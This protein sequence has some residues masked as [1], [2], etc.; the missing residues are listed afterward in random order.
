MPLRSGL[1]LA[2]LFAAMIISLAVLLG[3]LF[4][5][6]VSGSQR[7][8]LE[9]SD[10]MRRASAAEIAG[11]ID[12]RLGQA[13]IEIDRFST[14]LRKGLLHTF[15][16]EA[17]ETSF[18]SEFVGRDNLDE[19]TF[20]WAT[21][22][23]YD[24]SGALKLAPGQRGQISVQHAAGT[25]QPQPHERALITRIITLEDGRL[26]LRKRVRQPGM[27]P[28]AARLETL[29]ETP[30]DPT[31][32]P[33]FT[34]PASRDFA[35]KLLW[36]DLHW[37]PQSSH[38]P[39]ASRDVVVTLQQSI[40]DAD[41]RF[42][43]VLRL[44]LHT[45]RLDELARLPHRANDPNDTLRQSFAAA[46]R[47][48]LC[49]A[50][51]RLVSRITP[52]DTLREF[53]DVLRFVSPNMPAEV[54][55]ALG[56]PVLAEAGADRAAHSSRVVVEG[57]TYLVTFS[58]LTETQEWIVAIVVPESFYL[59]DIAVMRNRL[60]AASL[61]VILLIFIGGIIALR[62][63]RLGL[64]RIILQAAAMRMFSFE[65]MTPRSSLIEV[66]G[67]LENIESAKT[68][69]RAMSRY[70]PV[71]LVRELYDRNAEPHLGG[72]PRDLSIMFT[73]IQGFTDLAERLPPDRL[74]EALGLYLDAMTHAVHEHQGVIDKFIGDSVMAIW[75]A[76]RTIDADARQACAA[77]LA[78]IRATGELYQSPRWQGLPPLIT[79]IGIHK[80]RVLV[81]HF[82]APTR[83]NYTA[84]GD[85]VNAA[86]RLEG[87]SRYYGTTILVSGDIADATRTHFVFRH[88]DR[89]AVKGKRNGIELYELLGE[90]GSPAIDMAIITQYESALAL[91]RNRR[92]TEAMNLLITQ[93]HDTPSNVLAARCADFLR[94]PPPETW[95]GTW[96]FAFK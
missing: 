10:R 79:R 26:V 88:L 17:M 69:L 67:V 66:R 51:G 49:D 71:D 25:T 4:F 77:A 90:T 84:L 12:T 52:D 82:G 65:P 93:T 83:M 19:I 11:R 40:E 54:A 85:G 68:A 80:A 81:G 5:I 87:L 78:S 30:D 59:G 76:P 27:D 63:V 3:V 95:D 91:Y 41:G 6:I 24:E 58:P 61:V 39:D 32:H 18:L 62:L 13:D 57:K 44:G 60:L 50:R 94:E 72:E 46:H 36:S 92:F 37:S 75:N 29:A 53:G 43:G 55:A 31:S 16:P 1:S 74:A 15:D 2:K 35:G 89:V 34:T 28:L 7:A 47:V 86:S 20:T 33:T 21:P 38:L 96:V 23:G 64:D 73:D 56:S 70:V 14:H 45:G 48:F 22:D 9:I 8:V 42:L